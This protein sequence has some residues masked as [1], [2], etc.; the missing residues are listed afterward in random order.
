M[1]IRKYL[2]LYFH[3]QNEQAFLHDINNDDLIRKNKRSATKIGNDKRL[4]EIQIYMYSREVQV[5]MQLHVLCLEI[6]AN[7]NGGFIEFLNK[8]AYE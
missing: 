7:R 5:L 2:S 4:S 1:K 6:L 8:Y 3:S